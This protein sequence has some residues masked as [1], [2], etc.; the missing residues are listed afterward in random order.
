M[1]CLDW[2]LANRIKNLLQ[3]PETADD[4]DTPQS[5]PDGTSS[6]TNA[7]NGNALPSGSTSASSLDALVK[8]VV[9]S[10]FDDGAVPDIDLMHAAV[11]GLKEKA[12]RLNAQLQSVQDAKGDLWDVY[13]ISKRLR[14]AMK[15]SK[16][17]PLGV[18]MNEDL[19]KSI[20][21]KARFAAKYNRLP[22]LDAMGDD[23]MF[24]SYSS[25]PTA[26]SNDSVSDE[27]KDSDD[28]DSDDDSGD[29]KQQESA[30]KPQKGHKQP[31]SGAAK[32]ISAVI[33]AESTPRVPVIP[34]RNRSSVSQSMNA[35]PSVLERLRQLKWLAV[36]PPSPPPSEIGQPSPPPSEIQSGT[37]RTHE[38]EESAPGESAQLR[39]PSPPKKR[40]LDRDS[41]IYS[42]SSSSSSDSSSPS[43]GPSKRKRR[44]ADEDS[45]SNRSG[46]DEPFPETP[47]PNKRRRLGKTS[48]KDISR[49]E[50]NDLPGI[51]W[52][53]YPDLE[54]DDSDSSFHDDSSSDGSSGPED[55]MLNSDEEVE[56][57]LDAA[58]VLNSSEDNL[59]PNYDN[60]SD[61]DDSISDEED[62]ECDSDD[63]GISWISNNNEEKKKAPEASEVENEPPPPQ[64]PPPR[65]PRPLARQFDFLMP[66]QTG[67]PTHYIDKRKEWFHSMK[68]Y[69][70]DQ[71]WYITDEELN[72]LI[73]EVMA[74]QY[75]FHEYEFEREE[76]N[77]P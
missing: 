33:E 21:R 41:P 61:G 36:R 15:S 37:K 60:F 48:K 73:K 9:E 14:T 62:E 77:Y 50:S 29:G 11:K 6:A 43:E 3:P 75:R 27:S 68:K 19:M 35:S 16:S 17:W 69:F 49:T 12:T 71:D 18:P 76:D 52:K 1:D 51:V 58:G 67:R 30:A 40:R 24:M 31:V 26:S 55:D 22:E 4:T 39:T 20:R 45:A 28:S 65:K 56:I 46:S 70:H 72:A 32:E 47:S 34:Q 54:S 38:D 63:S 42:S 59:L 57:Q 74:D 66:D 25:D 64:S 7:K 5:R 53:D 10:K 13:T 44:R 8:A 23:E 2:L